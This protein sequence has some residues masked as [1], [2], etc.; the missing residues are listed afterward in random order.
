MVDEKAYEM[1]KG[2]PEMVKEKGSRMAG[3]SPGNH[4]RMVHEM[5][6]NL[7]E[8]YQETVK[9]GRLRS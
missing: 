7:V 6:R 1:V 8:N 9:N 2:W 4:H 5:V 3:K